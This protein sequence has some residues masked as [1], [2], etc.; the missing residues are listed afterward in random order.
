M[1]QN[2]VYKNHGPR[3]LGESIIGERETILYV[4]NMGK[5]FLKFSDEEPLAQK[6]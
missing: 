4:F 5:I 1:V 3:G 6:S 2:Q